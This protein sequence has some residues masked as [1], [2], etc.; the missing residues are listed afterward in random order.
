MNNA[1]DKSLDKKCWLVVALAT[2]LLV[3]FNLFRAQK[4]GTALWIAGHDLKH[5][6]T[7]ALRYLDGF[8]F[9]VDAIHVMQL[10]E[11]LKSLDQYVFHFVHP[12]IIAQMMK[13]TGDRSYYPVFYTTALYSAFSIPLAYY[14]LRKY[15]SPLTSLGASLFCAFSVPYLTPVRLGMTEPL[16]FPML[17]MIFIAITRIRSE[18]GNP[19]VS[20]FLLGVLHVTRSTGIILA[21]AFFLFTWRSRGI[22]AVLLFALGMA[23]PTALGY[24]IITPGPLKYSHT[25][26]VSSEIVHF[27]GPSLNEYQPER[28]NRFSNLHNYAPYIFNKVVAYGTAMI[29]DLSPFWGDFWVFVPAMALLFWRRRSPW[30]Y[31]FTVA[32]ALSTLSV[33]AFWYDARVNLHLIAFTL[34]FAVLYL[35]RQRQSIGRT[36]LLGAAVFALLFIIGNHFVPRGYNFIPQMLVAIVLA[37]P[38]VGR[39]A[40]ARWKKPALVT[41]LGFVLAVQYYQ[42]RGNIRLLADLEPHEFRPYQIELTQINSR[43]I[44]RNALILSEW[45]RDVTWFAGNRSV[46]FPNNLVETM[47]FLERFDVPKYVVL[48]SPPTEKALAQI[49]A[50][51]F[52]RLDLGLDALWIYGTSLKWDNVHAQL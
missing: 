48:A 19:F 16:M 18:I 6:G 17:V 8:G 45:S 29:R 10:H 9:R 39:A 50:V 13:L 11:S 21:P 1:I 23:I 30:F 31:F 37:L 44:P 28:L 24:W 40:Y 35:Y 42:T 22:R 47:K 46:Y 2:A 32:F 20:G 4:F 43:G 52:K 14:F 34:F 7:I 41:A 15:F 12:W 26:S 27:G 38:F 33:V 5:Y 25:Y 36:E 3:V 49:N 51:G